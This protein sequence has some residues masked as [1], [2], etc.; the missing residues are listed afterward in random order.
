MINDKKP[1]I[2][3]IILNWNGWRDTIKCLESLFHINYNNYDVILV[4]NGS[5]D[6]SMTKIKEYCKGNIKVN[7]KF[8]IF[9]QNNKPIKVFEY[10]KEDVEESKDLI[11]LKII[12]EIGSNRKI[13]IIR[14][15]KNLYFTGGSNVGI[16][17]ILENLDTDYVF[18]LNNDMIFEKNFLIE[19]IEYG[20]KNKKVGILGPRICQYDNPNQNQWSYLQNIKNPKELN[21]VSGG[22]ILIRKNVVNRIGYLDRRFKMYHDDWDFCLRAIKCGFL[23]VYIPTKDKILHKR[24]G[25]A[26][27]ISGFKT[28]FSVRNR[29]LLN[30][31]HLQNREFFKFFLTYIIIIIFKETKEAHKQ[32]RKDIIRGLISGIILVLKNKV[33]LIRNGYQKMSFYIAY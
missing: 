26:N 19:L 8:D 2:S 17:F 23:V 7:T 1:H 12:N 3:I 16:N 18:L 25:S 24:S 9:D 22:A 4:D 14:N 29:L 5:Q 31:K 21:I 33:F 28:Y 13:Q 6:D 15:S 32:I 30:K 27:T 20:E 10:T 11:D